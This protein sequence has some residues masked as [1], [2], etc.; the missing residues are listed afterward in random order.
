[1]KDTILSIAGRP[2]LY[3]LLQ[4]GRGM[5]IVEALDETKKRITAGDRDRVTSLND[6]SMYT[7]DGDVP[8]MTIFEGIFKM[9]A[10]QPLPLDI[11]KATKKELAD[12]MASALPEYDRDRVHPSDMKKLAQWYNILVKAGYTEFADPEDETEKE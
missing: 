6:V 10:G 9:Q 12:F 7:D 11:K 5:L 2:G 3:K 8:L 1:M 4:R